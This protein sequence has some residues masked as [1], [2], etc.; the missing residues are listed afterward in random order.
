MQSMRWLSS[1]Q[2]R[3]I[4]L[5]EL[6][7][8]HKQLQV[9]T[10]HPFIADSMRGH[11]PDSSVRSTE[12]TLWKL[13]HPTA[14]CRRAPLLIPT[15]ET[16]TCFMENCAVVQARLEEAR[17]NWDAALAS[18]GRALRQL[19]DSLAAERALSQQHQAAAGESYTLPRS[20]L[21]LCMTLI[22][23][24]PLLSSLCQFSST[25]ALMIPTTCPGSQGLDTDLQASLS[26]T[27]SG[28]Q[29]C[30]NLKSLSF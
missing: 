29:M 24:A 8:Q 18:K 10:A 6:M 22:C 9:K 14:Y 27:A 17:Q 5:L 3:D 12:R 30:S 4:E 28:L 1:L 21:L 2:D 25:I 16:H 13:A 26:H 20:L 7:E 15:V 19:G 11:Q 23:L